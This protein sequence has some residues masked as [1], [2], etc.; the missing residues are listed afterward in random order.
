[1]GW[2]TYIVPSRNMIPAA[3]CNK[4]L[5]EKTCWSPLRSFKATVLTLRGFLLTV[6][7]WFLQQLNDLPLA[8]RQT[9]WVLHGG[10]P[11]Q[12][13]SDV[14]RFIDSQYPGQWIGRYGPVM[15]PPW[16]SDHIPADLYMWGHVESI[17][18]IQQ[19][20]MWKNQ[21]MTFQQ[22][23]QQYTTC[24][25]SFSGPGVICVTGFS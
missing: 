1:M 21:G 17:V 3:V 19:C 2:R 14:V 5:G 20:N 13:S 18:Y 25:M 15:W 16:P 6:Y 22:L 23:G 9:M 10:T 7:E 12:S 24:L 4:Y 8:M 11:V